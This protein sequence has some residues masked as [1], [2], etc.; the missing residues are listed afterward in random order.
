MKAILPFAARIDLE[1][2]LL[3]EISQVEKDKYC[4][5]SLICGMRN[6]K[7][8]LNSETQRAD[9]QLPEAEVRGMEEL[10]KMVKSANFQF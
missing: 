1:G 9:Y 4:A 6:L 5:S 10:G 3:I 2:L 7:K 8:T